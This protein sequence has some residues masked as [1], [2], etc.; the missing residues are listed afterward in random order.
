MQK[1]A[2]EIAELW[3]DRPMSALDSA[4]YWTEYVARHPNAPPSLPSK[5][6]TWF[7]SLHVDLYAIL[8]MLIVIIAFL[9]YLILKLSL[10]IVLFVLR[11]CLSSKDKVE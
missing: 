11:K 4:I 3:H 5:K 8:L 10:V 6:S 7:D 9:I 1:R 2:K